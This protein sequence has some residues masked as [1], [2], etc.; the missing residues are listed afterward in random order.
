MCGR[1]DVCVVVFGEITSI[2]YSLLVARK[3]TKV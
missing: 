3:I 1:V 2:R